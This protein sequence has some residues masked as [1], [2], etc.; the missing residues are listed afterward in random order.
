M[1]YITISC[2]TSYKVK[3]NIPHVASSSINV[4]VANV[5]K[6]ISAKVSTKHD[7]LC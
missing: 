4:A 1:Y 2:S 7:V 6:W 3:G 5:V